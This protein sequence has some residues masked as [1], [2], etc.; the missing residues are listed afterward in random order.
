VSDA[1]SFRIRPAR[2]G[3]EAAIGNLSQL[4]SS[5]GAPAWATVHSIEDEI[6]WAK[7]AI[8]SADPAMALLVAV[9]AGEQVLGFVVAL[10]VTDVSGHR[11]AHVASIAVAPEAEGRGIGTTLLTAAESWCREQG[12]SDVTLHVYPGN[13]RARQVYERAGFEIEWHRL[14]KELD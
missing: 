12:F 8:E 11:H 3:D 13:E 6:A 7:S 2:A 10:P 5:V 9:D 4:A 14:R 1:P